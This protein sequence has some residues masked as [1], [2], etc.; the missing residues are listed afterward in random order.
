MVAAERFVDIHCHM[1]PNIDDGAKDWS[2]SLAMARMAVADGIQTVVVTPH[3]LGNYRQ[4]SGELIRQRTEEFQQTLKRQNISLRV[5]PGADV[6][7]EPEMLELIGRGEVL[8]L[9]DH[10]KHVLLELPHEV[11][12]P[13]QPLLEQM[14]RKRLVGILSHPE[15]NQGILR[16]T[17]PLEPLVRAGCMMQITAGSLMGTFGPPSKQLCEWMLARRLVHFVATDAHG[18]SSRRPLIGRAFDRVA[19][20]TDSQT[21]I[22]LCCTNPAAVAAGQ[23]ISIPKPLRRR[24]SL[25]NWLVGGRA[26]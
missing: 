15:R 21:A 8:T 4:N 25:L 20:L 3:Q 9:A 18:I 16:D 10:R 2:E 1:V 26:A 23:P 13:L 17:S 11:Y 7:I 19:E 24:K 5:L 22:Q 12:L 14:S 6:R